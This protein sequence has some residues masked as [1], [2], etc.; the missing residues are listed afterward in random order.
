MDGRAPTTPH[1]VRAKL[2]L[3]LAV[4]AV[5]WL[6]SACGSGAATKPA[7]TEGGPCLPNGT[8]HQGLTCNASSVCAKSSADPCEGVWCSGHGFCAVASGAA[9]CACD[10]GYRAE[11][12]DCVLAQDDAGEPPQDDAG[13]PPQDGG[14][15]PPPSCAGLAPT[16]GPARTGDCC[17]SN[18]VP[19]GTYY[20]SN[21]PGAPATVSDFRLDVYEVAVGRF[22]K[23]V[24]AGKG[25][26]ASPPTAGEGAHI[27]PSIAGSGWDAAW[28]TAGN[29]PADSAE[30]KAALKCDSS[31]QTWTDTTASN[32]NRPV[33]CVS[34]YDAFAF[35]IWDGGWLPTEAEWNYAAAGGSEQRFYPWSSPPTAT[36]IDGTYA[37][38]WV[39]PTQGCCGDGI[40]GCSLQDLVVVGSKAAGNGRWGHADLGGNV[41]EW[42]L[43]YWANGY[44]NPCTDCAN[45]SPSIRR[46]I[47]GGGFD[48]GASFVRSATRYDFDPAHGFADFGIRCARPL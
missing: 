28:N 40:T 34:W 27:G 9:T 43:D 42:V 32:E 5:V 26:L 25:T 4:I 35:C 37:S 33:N 39:D 36:V 19:G 1:G 47:R 21:D 16:C 38:Y 31:Y 41:F 46:M 29:L 24:D 11:A 44:D 10:T 12:L 18:L 30:L 7:G 22:R 3:I 14:G 23:F 6:G 8:C 2:R 48:L 17:A 45:L 15:V 13:E 20:R